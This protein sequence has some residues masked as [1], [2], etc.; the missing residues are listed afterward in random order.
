MK[1]EPKRSERNSRAW[2]FVVPVNAEIEVTVDAA[3]KAEAVEAAIDKVM[4]Q[5]WEGIRIV[6]T[7]E[8]EIDDD[9]QKILDDHADAEDV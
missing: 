9:L 8:P 4:D 7:G 6:D 1:T 2:A 5:D 3:S